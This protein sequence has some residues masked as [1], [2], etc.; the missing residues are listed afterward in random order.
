LFYWDQACGCPTLSYGTIPGPVTRAELND[1]N[2]GR[3]RDMKIHAYADIGDRIKQDYDAYRSFKQSF[4]YF[5]TL[6]NNIG[7]G[8]EGWPYSNRRV[9]AQK[10][11]NDRIKIQNSNSSSTSM[12]L[13][14]EYL[15]R[16][17][18]AIEPGTYPTPASNSTVNGK[19]MAENQGIWNFM[20]QVPPPFPQVNIP[21]GWISVRNLIWDNTQGIYKYSE[22]PF[23]HKIAILY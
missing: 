17:A 2:M 7:Y 18:W 12:S 22:F 19:S 23:S 16:M 13:P 10:W 15:L 5:G 3:C 1:A 14:I 20:M 8:P 6:F 4:Y 21:N 9:Q 11:I